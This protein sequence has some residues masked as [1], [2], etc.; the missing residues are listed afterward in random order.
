MNRDLVDS[1]TW[2]TL[3]GA[4]CLVVLDAFAPVDCEVGSG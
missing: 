1:P 3:R 2:R 4:W